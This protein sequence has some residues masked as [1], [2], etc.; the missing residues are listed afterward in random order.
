MSNRLRYNHSS[1]HVFPISLIVG[2]CTLSACDTSEKSTDDGY[3][4]NAPDV[5]FYAAMG[6]ECCGEDPHSVHGVET[7]DGGFVLCGKSIDESGGRD[8]FIVKIGSSLPTGMV[9]LGEDSDH[10]YSWSQT[11]GSAGTNEVA[12]AVASLSDAVFVVGMTTSNSGQSQRLMNKYDSLTGTLIWSQTFS[13][14]T[15]GDSAFESVVTTSDG[16]LILAGYTNG[17]EGSAEGFKSYGNPIGGGANVMYFSSEQLHSSSPPTA[18]SWE[19]QYSDLGSVRSIR[20]VDGMGY[21]FVASKTESLYVT[22]RIDDEGREE[23]RTALTDHGEATDLTVLENDGVQTGIAVVGHMGIDGGIDGS[24]TM[25]NLEGELQWGKNYG[26]PVGGIFEFS[27]LY[28][29]NPILIFDECWGVQSTDDG[30]MVLACG[31]GIEGCD[32]YGLGSALRSECRSDPR[33][34]WRSLILGIDGF[35]EQVWHRTDSYYF[36]E[37]NEAAA[38]ASEYIIVTSNGT[39]AS[40]IDQDFGIGLL[41]LGEI[42]E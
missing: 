16:G 36:D 7:T 22:V 27:G 42:L 5:S 33:T 17:E 2:L 13:E 6:E 4:D 31:T 28:E 30:G 37:E 34:K 14:S 29:G 15:D 12:N 35:G 21:V 3:S 24:V 20:V 11:F 38:S 41:Q 8:G 32:E 26:N 23:W 9:Y 25:L 18:P 40:V 19:Q 1:I 10:S 39:F